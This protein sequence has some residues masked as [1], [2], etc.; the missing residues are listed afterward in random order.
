MKKK[1]FPIA[2]AIAVTAMFVLPGLAFG[3]G[4]GG[5]NGTPSPPPTN[6]PC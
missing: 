4:G 1:I 6:P 5:N 3:A 2:V